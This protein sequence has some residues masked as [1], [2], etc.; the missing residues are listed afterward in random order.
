MTPAYN[1]TQ[2]K[3]IFQN[4]TE[5]D[6]E[7]HERQREIDRE[8]QEERAREVDDEIERVLQMTREAIEHCQELRTRNEEDD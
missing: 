1:K 5:E 8:Y 3:A 7:E 2:P 4:A 6:Q